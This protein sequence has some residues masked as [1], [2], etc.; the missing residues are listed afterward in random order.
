MGLVLQDLFQKLGLLHFILLTSRFG[1]LTAC[2][3]YRQG[4]KELTYRL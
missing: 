4:E 2:Y 1:D 3:S